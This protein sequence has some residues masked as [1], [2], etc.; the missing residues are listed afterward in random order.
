MDVVKIEDSV[1]AAAVVVAVLVA[2]VVAVEDEGGVADTEV[3]ETRPE[4]REVV[5]DE[6]TDEPK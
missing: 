4:G 5:E 1:V 3:E 2:V 6:S